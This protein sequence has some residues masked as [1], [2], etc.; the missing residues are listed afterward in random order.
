MDSMSPQNDIITTWAG[1]TWDEFWLDPKGHTYS[2]PWREGEPDLTKDE[3]A[4]DWSDLSLLFKWC[5][6]KLQ[7]TFDQNTVY[8]L[9]REWLASSLVYKVPSGEALRAAIVA[10]IDAERVMGASAPLG[11][12]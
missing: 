4:P 3:I 6:P 11:E 7:E 10:L 9:L 1:F 8:F 2:V 12:E 5:V